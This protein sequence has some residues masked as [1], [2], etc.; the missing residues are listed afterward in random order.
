MH[1][2]DAFPDADITAAIAL[3]KEDIDRFTGTTWGDITT[4]AYDGFTAEIERKPGCQIQLRDIENRPIVYP[5]TV[6]TAT[7][8]TDG[9]LVVTN[10]RLLQSGRI[11]DKDG[12]APSGWITIAGTA[13][14][15]DTP[16]ETIEWAARTLARNHLINE[17]SRVPDRALSQETELGGTI[18]LAQPGMVNPTGMPAVDARLKRYRHQFGPVF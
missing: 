3:A 4:P 15:L 14:R 17:A 11:V 13:G 10:W 1:D 12:T 8:E 9:A 18:R 16:D 6:T 5:R 7:H 2:T